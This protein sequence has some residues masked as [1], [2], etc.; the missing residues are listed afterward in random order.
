MMQGLGK[1]PECLVHNRV[2]MPRPCVEGLSDVASAVE[3]VDVHGCL[4]GPHPLVQ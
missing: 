3:D 4:D 1:V 2:V